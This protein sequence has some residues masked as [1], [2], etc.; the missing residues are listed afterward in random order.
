MLQKGLDLGFAATD[1]TNR[2]TNE[3][4]GERSADNHSKEW[5][6]ITDLSGD[7]G[8]WNC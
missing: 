2:S 4:V 5:C 3:V 7:R 1:T 6:H 8:D